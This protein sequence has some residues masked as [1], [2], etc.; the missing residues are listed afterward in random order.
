MK[1]HLSILLI[2]GLAVSLIGPAAAHAAKPKKKKKPVPV[3]VVYHIVW[4]G[5]GCALSTSTDMASD[6]DSCQDPFAGATQS[7]LG[8]GPFDMPALDGL[9]LTLDGSK[10]IKAHIS[11][12]S[13][14][15]VGLGPDIIGI[16][17]PQ[18]H[19]K[20][21]GTV[22]GNDVTI[23]EVTTDPYTVTPAAYHYTVDFE[24]P[25]PAELANKV[26]TGLT[27][28][29]DI[30]GKSLFHGVFPADGSSTLTVG[31]FATP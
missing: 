6:S 27:L 18:I 23:G 26:L 25:V 19:A 2:L 11:A 9:P 29:M 7:A 10:A 4:N 22:D 24:F 21:T 17:Q 15:A 5:D 30:E 1:R 3:D 14:G 13:Y 20:L 31:A 8:S 12:D 28:S 16:G